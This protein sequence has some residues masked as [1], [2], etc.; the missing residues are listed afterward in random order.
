MNMTLCAH[1]PNPVEAAVSPPFDLS[2]KLEISEK[3]LQFRDGHNMTELDTA[4][5]TMQQDHQLLS[6]FRLPDR[7]THRI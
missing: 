6:F 1:V 5:P 4:K 2:R 3:A 7:S